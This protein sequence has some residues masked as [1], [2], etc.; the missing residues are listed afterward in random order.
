[1]PIQTVNP[2]SLF[3]SF[4]RQKNAI[5]TESAVELSPVDLVHME[6][7]NNVE[8]LAVLKTESLDLIKSSYKK[9]F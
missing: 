2:A 4:F 1:M 8:R 5:S 3:I 9:L 7:D 6:F